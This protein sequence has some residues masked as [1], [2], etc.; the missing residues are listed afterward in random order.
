MTEFVSGVATLLLDKLATK[1]YQEIALACGLKGEVVKFQSKMKLINSYLMDAE[2]KQAEKSSIFEWLKQLRDIFDDA[3]DILDEIEY[4]AKRK[5]VIQMYGSTC[6]KVRRFFSCSS[7][8]LRFRIK[9]AHKIRDVI[10]RIDEKIREGTDLGIAEHI[11]ASTSR[12]DSSW[13]ETASFVP[14]RVTGRIEEKQNLINL[15]VGSQAPPESESQHGNKI[16]VIPIVGIGE[17]YTG[18]NGV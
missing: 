14:P 7:N 2:E 1:A 11:S 3:I 16:D 15:L 9:M 12:K 5:E 4:E 13:R 8:P 17:D 10:Q 18:P 6:S